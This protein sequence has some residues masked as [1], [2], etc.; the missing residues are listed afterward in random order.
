MMKAETP[1]LLFESRSDF[2]TWLSQNAQTTDGVWLVFGKS[3]AVATISAHDALE[4]ALCFGWI[5][6]QMQ[7]VDDDIYIKYFKQRSDTSKW[8][9]KNKLLAQ[10]LESLGL[11]TEFGRSKIKIAKQNGN[12]DAPKAEPMTEEQIGEFEDLLRSHE[13]AWINYEKM[14]RSARKAYAAS[15]IYTKTEAGKQK[16]LST[17]IE[18]LNLNLNPMES[19][20]K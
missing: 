1:Q 16:R 15:Y 11:I 17:I 12:W 5:D 20:K 10:K 18:R 19:M 4:E 13:T 7:S 8:S 3:K 14:P 6:G 2:R 9:E